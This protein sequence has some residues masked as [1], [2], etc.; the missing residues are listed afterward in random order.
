MSAKEDDSRRNG[1]V[2]ARG[3]EVG[4]GLEPKPYGVPQA[5]ALYLSAFFDELIA[6]GVRSV[7]ISPGSR[8][9]PLSMV[10][11]ES[12]LD[13]FIDI[14]ERGAAFL[15]LGL[16]KASGM[17]AC[18][19]CTSGTAVAN[20][21]PAVLEADASRVPLILLTADRPERDLNLGSPQTCDQLNA[22]GSNVRHFQ[23]MPLPTAAPA[24]IAFARQIAKEAFLHAV[25]SCPVPKDGG[26]VFYGCMGDAGPVQLNFP[27]E[28][29]LTPDL[30]VDGLFEIGRGPLRTETARAETAAADEAAMPTDAARPATPIALPVLVAEPRISAT[31]AE[32]IADLI[33]KRNTVV[34]AGEGSCGNSQ[35]ARQLIEWAKRN[36][37]PIIADPLSGLRSYDE[38]LIIDNYDT[39]FG[40]PECPKLDCVIRFGRYPISKTCFQAVKR[41]RPLQIVV[42][43]VETRDFNAATDLFVRCSPPAFIEAMSQYAEDGSSASA[44]A[45]GQTVSDQ[46]TYSQEWVALNDRERPRLL[47]ARD[48]Q[49]DFAAPFIIDIFDAVPADSLVF[50][51]SSMTIRLIDMFYCKSGKPLTLMCNRGL[52]GI[53]GTVSTMIGAARSFKQ[54]VFLTGDLTML[55]DMNALLLER[56]IMEQPHEGDIPSILIVLFNNNG[57]GL[58]SLLPQRSDDPYFERLFLVPQSVDY[59][60]MAR[61]FGIPYREAVSIGEFADAREELLGMLGISIIEVP[62]SMAGLKEQYGKY[63]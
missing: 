8:S 4:T 35:Q 34:F 16:A 31:Q 37:I 20:Y 62:L 25:G 15:A 40:K 52:N 55:H 44:R 61:T 11:F 12:P 13:V 42:D 10:A 3:A 21:Y 27:L 56:E 7:V 51:A 22:F 63:R 1:A 28:E 59:K 18:A 45:T 60:A 33:T 57:G 58:F 14:D 53:D 41:E 49:T 32:S 26:G 38:P 43:M 2:Q 23:Q 54:T 36:G 29:P 9:T 5:S 50:S 47:Q 30:S 46:A 24:E 48:V 39:L 19:I 17:P 6:C